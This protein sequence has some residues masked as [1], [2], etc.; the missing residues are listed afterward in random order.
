MCFFV[1]FAVP[2]KPE[3]EPEQ[4]EPHQVTSPTPVQHRYPTSAHTKLLDLAIIVEK[5]GDKPHSSKSAGNLQ[6]YIFF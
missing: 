6:F 2:E 1:Y 3:Q 5:E 4:Q